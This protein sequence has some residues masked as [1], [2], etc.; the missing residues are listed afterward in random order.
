MKIVLIVLGLLRPAVAAMLARLQLGGRSTFEV[1]TE[2]CRQNCG[3]RAFPS[4]Q[5]TRSASDNQF[6]ESC[7][8]RLSL[9][10]IFVLSLHRSIY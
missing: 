8:G 1:Q 2:P 7:L 10:A 3:F 5:C 6:A 4:K 9:T